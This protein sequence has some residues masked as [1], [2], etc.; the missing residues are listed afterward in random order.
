MTDISILLPTRGRTTA[1]ETSVMSLLEQCSDPARIE[2]LLSF[3]EDDTESS[4]WFLD[5]LAPKIQAAGGRYTCWSSPRLGYI[6]LNEYVNFLA[7]HAQGN[8]LMFW[9]DDAVMKTKN[10]DREICVHDGQFYVLRMPTHREHPYA[11]FPILPRA[12]YELFGYISPHQISDAWVSQM[13]YLLDI[14]RNILVAVEHDRHDLTGNNKDATF[15]QRVM[16]EG[17]PSDPKDFNH[18]GWRKKRLDD[19]AR[20]AGML[21]TRG[22]D[23]TWWENVKVGRQDAWVKMCSPEFDPNKQVS[24][25]RYGR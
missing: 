2:L 17:R 5:H 13:A 22:Q 19:T 18:E 12:W 6:R 24:R 25:E 7:G 21:T 4:Q 1:L 11:I 8:W 23:M 15:D 14:M 20:L 9:N 10:W 16:L 3:D